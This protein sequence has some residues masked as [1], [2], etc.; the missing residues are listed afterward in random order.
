MGGW[1]W[2]PFLQREVQRR[3]TSPSATNNP[4]HQDEFLKS[5]TSHD[6]F[7]H[8]Q[9]TPYSSTKFH[10]TTLYIQPVVL[11]SQHFDK[12][13]T[14]SSVPNSFDLF[15]S[16]GTP[17][18]FPEAELAPAAP[19]REQCLLHESRLYSTSRREFVPGPFSRWCPANFLTGTG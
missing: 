16:P 15:C 11:P 12:P 10:H 2:S 17:S 1:R 3:R 6:Y 18:I 14:I 8:R 7:V 5:V 9:T 19:P 4:E 13:M